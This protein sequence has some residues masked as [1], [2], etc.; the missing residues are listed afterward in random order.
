MVSDAVLSLLVEA[1]PTSLAT[2][3]A[4]E[5]VTTLAVDSYGARFVRVVGEWA[6]AAP[7][8]QPS[9]EAGGGE[10]IDVAALLKGANEAV[11]KLTDGDAVAY[12]YDQYHVLKVPAETLA[13]NPYNAKKPIKLETV[14]EP[15]PASCIALQG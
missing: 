9:E 7:A 5:G 10:A 11:G 15:L 12:Y 3:A 1:K 14:C 8:A 2:F 13:A 4:V 6:A